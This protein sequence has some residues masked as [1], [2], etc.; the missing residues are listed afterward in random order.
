MAYARAESNSYAGHQRSRLACV[1]LLL[2]T[3]LL[4]LA[5]RRYAEVIP[6][7]IARYAGDVLW[8]TMVA[9]LLGFLWPATTTRRLVLSA[10]AIAVTVELTQ[11]YHAPWI[12]AIRASR[13]GAL[14][15]GQGFLWTDLACYA[16]GACLAG[17]IDWWLV[18][19]RRSP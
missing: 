10:L 7:V 1:F 11:L 6:P 19:R 9:W 17:V 3:V 13:V 14:V 8:A 12:D 16:V 4:G 18:A 15:L 2:V 5:S